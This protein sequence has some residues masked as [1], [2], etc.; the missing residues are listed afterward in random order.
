MVDAVDSKSTPSNGVLVRVRSSAFHRT[1]SFQRGFIRFF[2]FLTL[3]SKVVLLL[4][5]DQK[6][7]D[8]HVNICEWIFF[9]LIMLFGD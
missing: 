2:H 4:F 7:F 8:E 5:K 1:N 6:S 3:L 9:G